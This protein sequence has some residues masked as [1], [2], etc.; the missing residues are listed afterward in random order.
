MSRLQ[1]NSQFKTVVITLWDDIRTEFIWRIHQLEKKVENGYKDFWGNMSVKIIAYLTGLLIAL[2]FTIV[3]YNFA[4][5][6][7]FHNYNR[8]M[9]ERLQSEKASKEDLQCEGEKIRAEIQR[10]RESFHKEMGEMKTL[11][12]NNGNANGRGTK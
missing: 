1:A 4:N 3:G 12:I 9:V 11:V 5:D 8:L 2:L 10:L 7:T 6:D